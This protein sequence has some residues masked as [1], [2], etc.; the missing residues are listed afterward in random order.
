[1]SPSLFSPP[2]VITLDAPVRVTGAIAATFPARRMK[3]PA[4]AA[5]APRG[6]T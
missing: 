4:E 6:V 5:C 2:I 1:M 3:K